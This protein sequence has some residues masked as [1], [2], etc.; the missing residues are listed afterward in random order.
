[1]STASTTPRV[2]SRTQRSGESRVIHQA[3]LDESPR[4]D[5]LPGAFA[6]QGLHMREDISKVVVERPREHKSGD[7]N[8]KRRRNDFDGPQFLGIRAGYGYRHLNENLSP[9]GGTCGRS[10]GAPGARCTARSPP[11]SIAATRCSSM[12]ISIWISS[13]PSMSGFATM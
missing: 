4:Q 7:A 12:C 6:F 1:T 10:W 5:S 11:E 3:E 8:A 2:D 9:C 13:S